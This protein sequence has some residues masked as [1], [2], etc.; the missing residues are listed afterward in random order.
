MFK[1]KA[2]RP[3]KLDVKDKKIIYELDFE[4]RM[5]YSVLAKRVGLSKQGAEYKVNNLMKKGVIKGF[6]PIINVPKLGYVYGR[7]C[8]SFKNITKEK[9]KEIITALKNNDKIFWIFTAQGF[10]DVLTAIWVENI[11]EFRLFIED[12]LMRYG[13]YI[14]TI[15]ESINT[16]VIHYQNRFLLKDKKTQEINIKETSK[17]VVIDA[18]DKAI[19]KMLCDD[20]RASLVHIAKHVGTSAKVV[21]YRIKRMEKE[22]LIEGYRPIINYNIL[23]YAYYKIWIKLHNINKLELTKLYE[24][25]KQNPIVLYLVKGIGFPGE[26]DMEVVVQSNIELYEFIKEL[27]LTFPS[28][29]GEQKIFMFMETKKVRFLPF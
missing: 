13:S 18:I 29:I 20:A 12:F 19:L 26:L 27:K 6:Y 3:I 24:F 25:L 17:R 23:G 9:E 10:F 28:M 2:L 7:F 8:F 22:K 4:A 21:A 11:S 16:E 14:D 5:P 1:M 15:N